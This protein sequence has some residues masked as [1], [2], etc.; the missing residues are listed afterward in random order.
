MDIKVR[1]KKSIDADNYIEA[2]VPSGITVSELVDM[3]GDGLPHRVLLAAVNNRY[4]ELW[5]KIESDSKVELYDIRSACAEECYR[6]SLTMIYLKAAEEVLGSDVKVTVENSLNQGFFSAVKTDSVIT[7][8]EL[9]AIEARMREIIAAD[10][11]FESGKS[12]KS[13]AVDLCRKNCKEE[14]AA[15]IAESKIED[16]VE[17]Y[18]LGDYYNYFFGYMVPSTGYVELFDIRKYRNGVLVRFPSS[19]SPDY[20]PE[21]RD[22]AKL[23]EAYAE[24]KK[25]RRIMDVEYLADLNRIIRE[26][27]ASELIEKNEKLQD[28][29]ILEIAE[30][31]I[32]SGKRIVLIAG[33]SSSGKTT[34]AKRLCEKIQSLGKKTLYLGTDD[35]F[36]DR[37]E[38]PLD[39]DGK[40]RFEDLDAIDLC[41]FNEHMNE[42]L[43]GEMV[44]LPEFN[45]VKGEKVFG[46]R[47]TS[48]DDEH[49]IVIEGIHSLNEEMT[50]EISEEVKLKI[51]I[52]PLTRLGIDRHNNLSTSDARKLRRMLRDY[53]TRNNSA[54]KTISDWQGVRMGEEKNIFPYSNSADIVFNSSV[55]YETALLKR[56]VLP[57]LENIGQNEPEYAEARRLIHFLKYFEVIKD[58]SSV[59]QNAILREFLGK[60]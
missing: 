8:E 33:P 38:T 29:K 50:S 44:D 26:G 30:T 43:A 54:A 32:G 22:D 37:D 11:P 10:I 1:I 51:Y 41:L 27:R 6:N 12:K 5:H 31:I 53:R 60:E 58:S 4:R 28:K 59:P 35:Y 48:I 17:Y 19:I 20:I 2:I 46:K 40:P 56:D 7:Q 3:F 25:W 42:L 15:L 14:K 9:D 36:L 34:F 13:K 21:Y 23:Y 24:A 39:A 49:L 57:L 16:D 45:F 18:S 55:T 47:I 52:S